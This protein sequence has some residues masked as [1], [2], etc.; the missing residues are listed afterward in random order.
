MAGVL[1]GQNLRVDVLELRVAIGMVR[2]LLGLAVDLAAIAELFQQIRNAC[3]GNL[4]SHLAQNGS[5]FGV[6]FRN[7]EQGAHRIADRGRLQQRA[8]VIK[9]RRI[10]SRQRQTPAPS[11]T[12]PPGHRRRIQLVQTALDRAARDAG[13][14]RNCGD[15]A[16]TR[17]A[18]LNGGKQPAS[19]LIKARAQRFKTKPNRYFVNHPQRINSKLSLGNPHATDDSV[20]STPRLSLGFACSLFRRVAQIR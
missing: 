15:A 3:L 9:K 14:P 7:P 8:Q 5:K 17:R 10:L 4:V 11:A 1:E 20:N 12:D 18:R 16:N 13:R 19:A 2:A 6:A